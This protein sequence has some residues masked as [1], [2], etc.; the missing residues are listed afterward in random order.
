MKFF[1]IKGHHERLLVINVHATLIRRKAAAIEEM[2]HL[3][4]RVPEHRGPVIL[5]GDFN[6]FTAGYLHA[7]SPVL[8]RIGLRYVAIPN[9]PRPATQCLDQVFCRGL[10]P[11]NVHVDTTIR[12]SDHFPILADFAL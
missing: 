3:L 4:A 9:D 11:T 12:N 8:G 1:R 5:A 7:I 2:E 6:T 10:T